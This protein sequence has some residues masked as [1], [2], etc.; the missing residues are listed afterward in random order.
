MIKVTFENPL[1]EL[2]PEFYNQLERTIATTLRPIMRERIHV[3]GQAK[4]G[5]IGTYSTKETYINTGKTSGRTLQGVGKTGK[6]TFADGRKHVTTY[7]AQGYGQFKKAIGRA[8]D[9]VNLFLS[10]ELANNFTVIGIGNVFGLGWNDD[11]LYLRALALE[12]KYQKPIWD[13][14]EE[15]ENIV[16]ETADTELDA[17]LNR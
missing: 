5:V 14:T 4:D 3:E 1:A 2:T 15:E 13:V 17:I 8:G 11:K 12:K 6:T 10:G 9:K 7:F 16:A